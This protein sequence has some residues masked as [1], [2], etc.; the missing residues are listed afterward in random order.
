MKDA[1]GN[2]E[3]VRRKLR[4]LGLFVGCGGLDLGFKQSGGFQ[5]VAANEF[6]KPAAETYRL[7]NSDTPLIEG[8]ITREETKQAICRLF[9]KEPCEAIIGGF[10]CQSNSVAGNRNPNDPRGRLYEDYMEIVRQL[11]PFVVVMENVSGILSMVRADGVPVMVWIAQAFSRLGYAVGYRHLNA[12]DFGVAQTRERVFIFAWRRGSM[13]RIQATH[14][15]RGKN[16]LSRWQ[17]FRDTVEGLP[18]AQKDFIPFPE[19]RMR[20]LRLLKAGQDWRNLPSHL[21]AEAMGKLIEWGGGSTGCFRRL[22][23]DKPAPT[24]TC[25]PIQKMTCLCHPVED[26]P[27]SIPEYRRVQGFPDDYQLS[28]SIASQYAQLGNAVPVGVAR[29]VA[30]AI[31]GMFPDDPEDNG[32]QDGPKKAPPSKQHRNA[33]GT[34][35]HKGDKGVV[36]QQS[37]ARPLLKW[38]GGKRQL[39]GQFEP[40]FPMELRNGN[41]ETYVEPFLGGAAVFLH[42][43]QTYNIGKFLLSDANPDLVLLYQVAKSSPELLISRLAEMQAAYLALDSKGQEAMFLAIRKQFNI[44]RLSLGTEPHP[45]QKSSI[46]RA[47]DVV[48][49]NKTCFNGIFKMNSKGECNSSFGWHKKPKIADAVN[50]RAVSRILQ[51]AEISTMDFETALNRVRDGRTFVYLDPPYRPIS[52]TSGFTAYSRNRFGDDQQ[53]KLAELYG[54]IDRQTNARLMLSNSAPMAANPE[55]TFL[56]NL[57]ADYRVT[58]V[59]ASRN[60]NCKGSKRGRVPEIVVT[61]Y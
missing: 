46:L 14:D 17:T 59:S 28:G 26:R 24:L 42:L 53:T 61:N 38:A 44:Q 4:T 41:I 18:D 5:L 19:K 56:K 16:G 23:W 48:F 60:I 15:E 9:D 35:S 21:Q 34:A 45:D 25:N 39:L 2:L 50:I 10:P 12:A 37:P 1:C 51:R 27:L 43:A 52:A 33:K 7:N 32:N 11:Y 49:M 29:V 30:A 57:Y 47:A 40:L 8:D 22:S 3:I 13:P 54:R 31:R 20:F 36:K 55:D 6:W 58:R